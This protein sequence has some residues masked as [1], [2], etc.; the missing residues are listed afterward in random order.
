M[1]GHAHRFRDTFPVSLLR[2]VSPVHRAVEPEGPAA[3]VRTDRLCNDGIVQRAAQSL[4]EPGD[5]AIQQ[6]R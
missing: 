1:G 5:H 6:D 3:R 2:R 4:S